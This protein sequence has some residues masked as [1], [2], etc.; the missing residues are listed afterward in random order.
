MLF[1]WEF[2]TL[3]SCG[4]RM[5]MPHNNT[6]NQ[7]RIREL[8]SWNSVKKKIQQKYYINIYSYVNSIIVVYLGGIC[9]VPPEKLPAW[10]SYHWQ[11]YC[12]PE[13]ITDIIGLIVHRTAG[14]LSIISNAT[15]AIS[16]PF[17]VLKLD[18]WN[19]KCRLHSIRFENVALKT[20]HTIL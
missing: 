15:I 10:Q 19:T 9:C 1:E 6:N 8:S 12:C 7:K 3:I 16:A 2:Q 5:P 13:D 4:S 11:R 20:L 14:T 18:E 17:D